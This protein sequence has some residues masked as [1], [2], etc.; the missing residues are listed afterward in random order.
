MDPNDG[1]QGES[2]NFDIAEIAK[3]L[4]EGYRIL[5]SDE[6]ED[7]YLPRD[8][9]REQYVPQTEFK[10]RLRNSLTR[11]SALEDEGLVATILEKH[12]KK[13]PDIDG[14]KEQW[15]AAELAPVLTQLETM[16]RSLVSREVEQEAR[17]LFGEQAPL[18]TRAYGN[19]FVY[20][21]ELGYTVAVSN[22]VPIPAVNPT[23][24]RP[25]QSAGEYFAQ[26]AKTDAALK[27]ALKQDPTNNSGSNFKG[28][29]PPAGGPGSR[30]AMTEA[31]Q[32]AY[33]NTHGTDKYLALPA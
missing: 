26:K 15:R 25:Y 29:K 2:T 19:D 17:E 14:A 23:N 10:R 11:E 3:S 27:A 7:G 16:T 6:L 24:E 22:G 12:G 8:V 21:A 9:V 5:S 13:T 20:D 33:I 31:E 32:V 30:S 28:G 18:V 4:P 1:T